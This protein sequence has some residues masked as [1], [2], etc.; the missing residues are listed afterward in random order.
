[1]E[2]PIYDAEEVLDGGAPVSNN[3]DKGPKKRLMRDMQKGMLG[4]VF[5]GLAEYLEWEVSLI[6]IAY[7]ILTI[8]TFGV[9][10]ALAYLFLWILLP[11]KPGGEAVGTS[12]TAGRIFKFGCGGCLFLVG[13]PLLIIALLLIIPA[14]YASDFA[15]LL[16]DPNFFA[17][18]DIS[19]D[20]RYNPNITQ[21]IIGAFAAFVFPL[22]S[23]VA[24]QGKEE[25]FG[26][27]KRMAYLFVGLVTVA[28]LMMVVS[29]L[30]AS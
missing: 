23:F 27:S 24:M 22:I 4:G 1:M 9:F 25:I 11:L 21:L 10:S 28:G 5:A 16:S 2:E 14:I 17:V 12:E 7:V 19:W 13:F 8:F 29:A 20:I 15:T 30:T 26:I 3:E 18:D 6:R